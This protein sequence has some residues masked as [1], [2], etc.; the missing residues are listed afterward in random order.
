MKQ[1]EA[2][3]LQ[4]AAE[5]EARL[6]ANKLL[7]D[8]RRREADAKPTKTRGILKHGTGLDSKSDYVTLT[9]D[10]LSM[11]LKTLSQVQGSENSVELDVGK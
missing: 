2:D 7:M 9:Q 3:Q 1:D 5:R 6:R 11:I 10:Q 8:R 4:Q